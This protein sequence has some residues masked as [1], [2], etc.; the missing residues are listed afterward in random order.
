MK[1][2][3][4]E[5]NEMDQCRGIQEQRERERSDGKNKEQSVEK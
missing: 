5:E 3:R 1:K 2:R 4:T